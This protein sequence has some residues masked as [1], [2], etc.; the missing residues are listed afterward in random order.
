MNISS[1]MK[2]KLIHLIHLQT[3]RLYC[4]ANVEDLSEVAQH[5]R[6]LYPNSKIGATGISMGSLL[7]GNYLAEH[8]DEARAIFTACHI[9]SSPYAVHKVAESIEKPYLNC[10]LDKH[11]TSRLCTI[12]SQ[13]EIIDKSRPDIDFNIILKS[14]TIREFDSNFTSKHFGYDDV[15]HYYTVASLHEKLHKISVPFLCLSAADDP[16]QPFECKY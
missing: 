7:L 15:E 10:I 4:A 11:L 8:S 9:I 13:Y 12:L 3:P 2:K 5:I 1:E 6:K 14:K 16:F